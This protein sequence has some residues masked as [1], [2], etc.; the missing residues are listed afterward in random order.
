[1]LVASVE[2]VMEKERRRVDAEIW[3]KGIH[4]EVHLLFFKQ[5]IHNTRPTE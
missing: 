2:S 3:L 5:Y 4:L 1:M